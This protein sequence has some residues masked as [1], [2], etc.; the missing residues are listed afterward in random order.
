MEPAHY[1]NAQ[2]DVPDVRR[3]LAVV[4]EGAERALET[5]AGI[6]SPDGVDKGTA[7]LLAEVPDPAPEGNLLDIGCGW[8]PIAL[9]MALRSPGATVH[10]VD[11]NERSLSLTAANARRLG[12]ENIRAAL[13]E[14]VPAG[15]RFS[16]IWSNPPIR[17]GKQALH[18]LLLLWLPRLEVGG[19]AWLVVQKNLG[20]DSLQRWLADT[21]GDAYDVG[22]EATSKGFRLLRVARRAEAS[23]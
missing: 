2:P 22:R 12:L 13:P 18:E 5:S 23:S 1:F 7:V 10:A 4:L 20:A 15:T 21:L 6:F 16:T 19:E 17:I 11:V 14:D 9:T 3:P 8:G